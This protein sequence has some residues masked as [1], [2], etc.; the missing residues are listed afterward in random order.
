MCLYILVDS[1]CVV[2]CMSCW[3]NNNVP[4]INIHPFTKNLNVLDVDN[5]DTIRE[6]GCKSGSLKERFKFQNKE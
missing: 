3:Y 1:L 6:D 2:L 4:N 5:M